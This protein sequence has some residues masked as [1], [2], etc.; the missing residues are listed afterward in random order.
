MQVMAFLV[1][2]FLNHLPL[3]GGLIQLKPL[4]PRIS[5]PMFGWNW[6]CDSWIGI[7]IVKNLQIMDTNAQRHLQFRLANNVKFSDV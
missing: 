1:Q 2:W 4:Y 3:N 6:Q 7:Q 5:G